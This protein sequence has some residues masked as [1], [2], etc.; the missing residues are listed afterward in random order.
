ML[1]YYKSKVKICQFGKSSK[2]VTAFKNGR[3]EVA[4]MICNTL[5]FSIEKLAH[6]IE[7]YTHIDSKRIYVQN[8]L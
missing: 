5:F 2:Y 8:S 7:F 6:D 1:L 4:T 3:L